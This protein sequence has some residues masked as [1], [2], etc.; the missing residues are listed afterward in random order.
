MP[1][2]IQAYKPK[3]CNRAYIQKA[4]ARQHERRCPRNP[5]NKACATCGYCSLE[6]ETVYNPYHNGNPG[7]TD[8]DRKYYW[9]DFF[10]KE[11]SLYPVS[12][13]DPEKYMPYQ[14]NCPNWRPKEEGR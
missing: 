7:S 3:C 9:C 11:L 8:Y 14:K 2:L 1:E 4:S 5:D 10:E 12:E 6:S 13:Q